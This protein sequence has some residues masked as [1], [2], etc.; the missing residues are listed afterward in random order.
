M[1]LEDYFDEEGFEAEI[2]EVIPKL[3]QWVN[4]LIQAHS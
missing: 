2:Q 3:K 4:E 1:L